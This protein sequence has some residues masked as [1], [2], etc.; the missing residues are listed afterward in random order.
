M[1]SAYSLSDLVVCRS[2]ALTL[3]EITACG[4]PSILI[5][6][7]AAAGNH[8]LKNAETLSKKGASILIEEKDLNAKVLLLNINNLINNES[9]LESMSKASKNLGNPEAT[10]TIVEQVIKGKHLV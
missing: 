6:F 9:K 5:P 4:K 1:A 7:A 2:G 3:S 10:K 8:Q